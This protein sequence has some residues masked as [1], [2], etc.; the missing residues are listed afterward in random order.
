M[1]RKLTHRYRKEV[2]NFFSGSLVVMSYHHW[3]K[4]LQ[5]QYSLELRISRHQCG[6][7]QRIRH[8]LYSNDTKTFHK[9]KEMQDLK[10][11]AFEKILEHVI[12]YKTWKNV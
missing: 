1:K 6:L 12:Y 4:N 11:K 7:H 9:I 5:S 8:H 10:L 2:Y 3:A